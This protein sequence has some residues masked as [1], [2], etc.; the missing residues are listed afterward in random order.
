MEW[1]LLVMIRIWQSAN[2]IAIH[3][4][5]YTSCCTK[6]QTSF[7]IVPVAYSFWYEKGL[8]VSTFNED[9]LSA[10]FLFEV[11]LNW[12]FL[13]E[14][15]TRNN[16]GAKQFQL[17]LICSCCKPC[18]Q[19]EHCRAVRDIKKRVVGMAHSLK[20]QK[21]KMK[22]ILHV[23]FLTLHNYFSDRGQGDYEELVIYWWILFL[24]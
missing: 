11:S 12:T 8:F 10:Q 23:R 18:K 15:R 7:L 3:N 19:T 2:N 4:E 21:T 17:E 13:M 24:I 14:S 9:L 20:Y 22:T 16:S 5:N 1:F 6:N